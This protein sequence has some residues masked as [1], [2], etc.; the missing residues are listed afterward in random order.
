MVAAAEE[1][2]PPPSLR[3]SPLSRARLLWLLAPGG[4]A[5]AVEGVVVLVLE[6]EEVEVVER[7]SSPLSQ[8][9]LADEGEHFLSAPFPA[10]LPLPLPLLLP[11][12]FPAA[13]AALFGPEDN[14]GELGVFL[15]AETVLL[16]AITAAGL[17]L[18][19]PHDETFG[20][21]AVLS[22]GLVA[23]C[24]FGLLSEG[25]WWCDTPEPGPE[26]LLPESLLITRPLPGAARGLLSGGTSS[27]G[28]AARRSTGAL[29]AAAAGTGSG[30]WSWSLPG[31]TCS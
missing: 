5:G 18:L 29:A 24:P 27:T 22:T 7:S 9:P 10:L 15:D 11:L 26:R 21:C 23:A 31:G 2:P 25:G 19:L 30:R 4:S 3:W 1:A 20:A 6:V 13:E 14:L 17:S 16:A 28:S 8:L 12:G